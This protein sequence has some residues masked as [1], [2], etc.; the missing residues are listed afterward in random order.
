MNNSPQKGRPSRRHGAH[1][2]A[3]EALVMLISG[4]LLRLSWFALIF[5]G[6]AQP[7][8]AQLA[9][10]DPNILTVRSCGT[11]RVV[12]QRICNPEHCRTDAF[13]QSGLGRK[14]LRTY[15]IAEVNKHTSAFVASVDIEDGKSECV[16]VL[17]V[18]EPHTGDPLF[19]LRIRPQPQGGY[20]QTPVP[21]GQPNSN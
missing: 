3:T 4:T 6:A 15:P 21:P 16:F 19:T 14:R 20:I 5:G 9:H 12:V 11:H 18:D 13:L 2:E 7:A 10:L 8:G 1:W 17:K